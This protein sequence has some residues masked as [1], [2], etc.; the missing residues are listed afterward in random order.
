M[1]ITLGGI[2]GVLLAAYL[3]KE[4]P[5]K[6]LRWLVFVVMLYTAF[7]MLRSAVRERNAA[8]KALVSVETVELP[9]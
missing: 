4:L 7:M 5:L 8:R 1:G 9:T 6:Q 3:V 2:P